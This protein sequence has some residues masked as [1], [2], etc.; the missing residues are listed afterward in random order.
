MVGLVAWRL[1]VHVF[2][3]QH[4]EEGVLRHPK[5]QHE[6][7]ALLDLVKDAQGLAHAAAGGYG[8]ACS[9]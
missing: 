5:D 2:A 1:L 3:L 7:H 6:R 9:C 8:E 4:E